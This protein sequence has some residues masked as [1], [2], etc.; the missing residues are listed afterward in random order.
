MVGVY[1][2]GVL[3][4]IEDRLIHCRDRLFKEF[5]KSYLRYIHLYNSKYYNTTTY[6]NRHLN[7]PHLQNDHETS[8]NGHK[9]A[10]YI[11]A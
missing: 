10:H 7:L 5:N 2:V 9:D 6:L 8:R 3:H 11:H 1:K 4:Q